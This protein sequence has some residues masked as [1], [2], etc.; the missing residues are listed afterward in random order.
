MKRIFTLAV[1]LLVLIS[2]AAWATE[3][4]DIEVKS[5]CEIEY[6]CE[7]YLEAKHGDSG[8]E[9]KMKIKGDQKWITLKIESR[10]MTVKEF[11]AYDGEWAAVECSWG[12]AI[13]VGGGGKV[14]LEVDLKQIKEMAEGIIEDAGRDVD[15]DGDGK[16]NL[17]DAKT[18]RQNNY[19]RCK[20]IWQ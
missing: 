16:L 15:A 14:E 11:F 19:V 10:T 1:F 17:N 18:A 7:Y 5:E 9:V 6:E 20:F 8:P 3:R 2:T 12:A 4:E 13:G